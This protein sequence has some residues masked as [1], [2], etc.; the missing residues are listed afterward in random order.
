MDARGNDADH[1]AAGLT[2]GAMWHRLRAQLSLIET[3]RG[4]GS[5]G[6][7]HSP[8]V[9]DHRAEHPLHTQLAHRPHR[10]HLEA[11]TD[12]QLTQVIYNLAQAHDD[13]WRSTPLV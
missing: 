6:G 13:S 12:G 10:E 7:L 11:V 8:S 2:G 5:A 1:H 9:A 4:R 3:C